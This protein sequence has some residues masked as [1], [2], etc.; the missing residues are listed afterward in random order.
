YEV[1][2]RLELRGV[3]FR[4]GPWSD[5]AVLYKN[6]DHRE[7][8]LAELEGREIPVEVIGADLTDT[9]ALRDLLSAARAVVRPDDSVALMRT[10]AEVEGGSCEEVDGTLMT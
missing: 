8:V 7:A 9:T 4:S 2:Q 3:L 1:G 5:F 6:N 10:A